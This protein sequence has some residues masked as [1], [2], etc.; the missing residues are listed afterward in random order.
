MEKNLALKQEMHNLL[1][2]YVIAKALKSSECQTL[3]ELA[4]TEIGV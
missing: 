1:I 3:T 4:S 2:K